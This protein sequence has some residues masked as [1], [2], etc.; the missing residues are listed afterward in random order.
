M[1]TLASS[2]SLGFEMDTIP[3]LHIETNRQAMR[4]VRG[5]RR[6]VD[7]LFWPAALTTLLGL[8]FCLLPFGLIVTSGLMVRATAGVGGADRVR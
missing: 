5:H 8:L 6:W 3:E 4:T 7:R 2:Q 1:I